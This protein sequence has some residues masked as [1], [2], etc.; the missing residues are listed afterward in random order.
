MRVWFGCSQTKI[1]V[2]PRYALTFPLPDPVLLSRVVS[3]FLL[4][5]VQ[6]DPSTI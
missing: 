2:V 4:S 1:V 3:T 5:A 6:I